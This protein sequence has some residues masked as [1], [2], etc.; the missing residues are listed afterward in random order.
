MKTNSIYENP[1]SQILFQ[2][3]GSGSGGSGTRE[4]IWHKKV[5]TITGPYGEMDVEVECLLCDDPDHWGYVVGYVDDNGHGYVDFDGDGY[6]DSYGCE[7]DDCVGYGYDSYGDYG[8]GYGYATGPYGSKI[9]D[10]DCECTCS[11]CKPKNE[12]NGKYD[13]SAIV[14]RLLFTN[15]FTGVDDTLDETNRL[16]ELVNFVGTEPWGN[17]FFNAATKY[18]GN[19]SFDYDPFYEHKGSNY[20]HTQVNGQ[21]DIAIREAVFTISDVRKSV[22]AHE[23]VEAYDRGNRRNHDGQMWEVT[24][25]LSELILFDNG[26]INDTV[27]NNEELENSMR[28]LL[29]AILNN[30]GDMSKIDDEMWNTTIA[31]INA[32]GYEITADKTK[33]KANTILEIAADYGYKPNNGSTETAPEGCE[34]NCICTGCKCTHSK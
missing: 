3:A 7:C 25:R 11:A 34:C 5:T 2:A 31:R 33:F 15:N 32:I 14:D 9:T 27:E 21:E 29:N 4:H 19:V 8:Y 24:S 18:N 23:V 12:K 22:V 30:N 17:R 13:S 10:E 16:K 28:P 26:V 1:E 6:A 20:V